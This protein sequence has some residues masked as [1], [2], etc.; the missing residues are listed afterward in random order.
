MLKPVSFF[1]VFLDLEDGVIVATSKTGDIDH[2][3]VLFD[4]LSRFERI[5]VVRWLE[6]GVMSEF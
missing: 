6:T 4:L 5:P 1:L 2:Y 3:A